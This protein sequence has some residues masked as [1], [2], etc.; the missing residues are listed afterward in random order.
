MGKMKTD[1]VQFTTK[2]SMKELNDLL[3]KAISVTRAKVEKLDS[4]PIGADKDSVE[5]TVAV[6]LSSSNFMGGSRLWGVQVYFY[7]LGDRR[8]AELVAVGEGIGAGIMSYY[9]GGYFQLSDGK[10]RRDRIMAILTEGDLTV[11]QGAHPDDNPSPAP[12]ASRS[13]AQPSAGPGMNSASMSSGSGSA[14][15]RSDKK[16][17]LAISP[18]GLDPMAS[19]TYL[20]LCRLEDATGEMS[21]EE[22]SNFAYSTFALLCETFAD[23]RSDFPCKSELKL[24]RALLED[25]GSEQRYIYQPYI[26]LFPNQD[27]ALQTGAA[28]LRDWVASHPDDTMA[29]IA[30]AGF[31]EAIDDHDAANEHLYRALLD[32]SRGADLSECL[33]CWTGNARSSNFDRWYLQTYGPRSAD[34]PLPPEPQIKGNPAALPISGRSAPR[35]PRPTESGSSANTRTTAFPAPLSTGLPSSSC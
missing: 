1:S 20:A 33:M 30:F 24:T 10:H 7:E 9:T 32:E 18:D 16:R 4:D 21:N 3:R 14:Q 22:K 25:E 28:A 27:E 31:A 34:D 2:R 13:I 17:S 19:P 35:L 8:V 29:R 23:Q 12:A 6:L 5:P 11:R 26:D 15:S